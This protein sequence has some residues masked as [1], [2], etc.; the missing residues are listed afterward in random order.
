M[1]TGHFS[2]C[3]QIGEKDGEDGCDKAEHQIGTESF[4]TDNG[5]AIPPN[6]LV[7]PDAPDYEPQAVLP[8]AN[9]ASKNGYHQ[10]CRDRNLPRHL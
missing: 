4:L 5:G 2:L 3:P 8:I 10:M 6:V 9:T 7:P 1:R